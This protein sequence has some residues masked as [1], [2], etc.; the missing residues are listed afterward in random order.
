MSSLT[1]LSGSLIT[2][3]LILIVLGIFLVV[4]YALLSPSQ[5]EVSGGFTIF[6][7]PIPIA[8]AW[9]PHGHLLLL[10]SLIL[11]ITMFILLYVFISSMRKTM[12]L[13]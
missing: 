7:G 13:E 2:V 11:A 5:G 12:S 8:G 3:G 1:R 4:T 9:G 10:I 6:V